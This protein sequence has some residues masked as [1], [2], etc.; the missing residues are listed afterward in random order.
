VAQARALHRDVAWAANR[1]RLP[2]HLARRWN[3]E[4]LDLIAAGLQR[5]D[6]E[7]F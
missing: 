2:Q 5:D 1:L 7:V 6:V 4:G 3:S